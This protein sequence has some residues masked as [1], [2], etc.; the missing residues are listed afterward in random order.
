MGRENI[1]E[2]K[3]IEELSK[4]C[5]R[6]INNVKDFKRSLDLDGMTSMQNHRVNSF[7]YM[8]FRLRDAFA[9]MKES[10]LG[11]PS[12][13]SKAEQ[14]GMSERKV[15]LHKNFDLNKELATASAF[16]SDGL[17]KIDRIKSL[18]DTAN[19]FMALYCIS[20]GIERLEK[21]ILILTHEDLGNGYKK[22]EKSIKKHYHAAFMDLIYGKLPSFRLHEDEYAFLTL[23]SDFY[24]ASR[25]DRMNMTSEHD[26][27]TM[28]LVQYLEEFCP[29]GITRGTSGGFVIN[30]E[31]IS[32]LHDTTRSVASLLYRQIEHSSA[33]NGTFTYEVDWTSDSSGVLAPDTYLDKENTVRMS[34]GIAFK[35]LLIYLRN[36]KDRNAFLRFMDSFNPLL[37]DPGLVNDYISD[38]VSGSFSALF[39]EVSQCYAD[40][41]DGKERAEM[42]SCIGNPHCLF[43]IAESDRIFS[44][45]KDF[46]SGVGNTPCLEFVQF[47]DALIAE[48]GDSL[49]DEML[50]ELKQIL[51]DFKSKNTDNNGF[52]DALREYFNRYNSD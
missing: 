15:F 40:L 24:G 50:D 41:E 23:L 44:F 22:F 19:V 10:L 31:A 9:E 20:V 46:L 12:S 27:E 49:E 11:M 4:E 51:E 17:A 52:S 34:N 14:G 6:L 43:D 13:G 16:L 28:L 37:L 47:L 39:D 25:Y 29:K 32:Y 26:M 38:A 42:I 30:C 36:T 48:T 2:S 1:L 3:K 18:S 7:E 45:I 33:S 21:V 35:E 5:D 8:A